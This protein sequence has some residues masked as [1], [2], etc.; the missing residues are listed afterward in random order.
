MADNWSIEEVMKDNY[1]FAL[2]VK[3]LKRF[4]DEVNASLKLPCV[5]EILDRNGKGLTCV[6]SRKGRGTVPKQTSHDFSTFP[7]ALP[8]T[9][10]ATDRLGR[11]VVAKFEGPAPS[12]KDLNHLSYP[13]KP[14]KRT[15]E[16][17]GVGRSARSPRRARPRPQS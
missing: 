5:M 4:F 16:A 7:E 8:W 3:T 14:R 13:P 9:F 17:R 1:W 11:K 2:Y 12:T 15:R 10:T 6:L